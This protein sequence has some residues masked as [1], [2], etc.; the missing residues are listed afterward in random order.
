VQ[1]LQQQ[2]KSSQG[3]T[4]TGFG[5]M[6]AS[7]AFGDDT[8]KYTPQEVSRAFDKSD[9]D[10]NGYLGVRDLRTILTAVGIS[11]SDAEIDAMV[12]MLDSNADGQVTF[13]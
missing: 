3:G 7:T 2:Q 12:Q 8:P 5:A 11:A 6:A 10:G 4:A 9:V 1:P 13:E